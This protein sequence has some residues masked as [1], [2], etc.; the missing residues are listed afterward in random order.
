MGSK[1]RWDR[2]RGAN[3]PGWAKSVG[4]KEM[5]R[6]FPFG[7]W[8][9]VPVED[10]PLTYLAWYFEEAEHTSDEL[11]LMVRLEITRRFPSGPRA[12]P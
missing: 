1:L 9:E 12:T 8:K 6:S 7:K 4:R 3:N 11:R 10:V 2:P 5:P